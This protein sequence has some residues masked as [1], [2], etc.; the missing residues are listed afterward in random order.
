M[1]GDRGAAGLQC[2]DRLAGSRQPDCCL[3]HTFDDKALG[4]TSSCAEGGK[5]RAAGNAWEEGRGRRE[6]QPAA[7]VATA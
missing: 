5:L 4:S 7:D 6:T 1:A 2:R 3:P